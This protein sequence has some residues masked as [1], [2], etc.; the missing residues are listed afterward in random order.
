MTPTDYEE[1]VVEPR[2]VI[3]LGGPPPARVMPDG[4]RTAGRTR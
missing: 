1:A 4:A 2:R 3:E